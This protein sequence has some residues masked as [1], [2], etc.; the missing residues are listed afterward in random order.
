MSVVLLQPK[1]EFFGRN[2]LSQHLQL[3]CKGWTNPF[4]ED[5]FPISPTSAQLYTVVSKLKQSALTSSSV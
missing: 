5:H 4:P 1:L 3:L 2:A